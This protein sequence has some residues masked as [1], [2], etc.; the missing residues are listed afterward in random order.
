MPEAKN[1]VV[2]PEVVKDGVCQ[3]CHDSCQTKVH[4]RQGKATRIDMVDRGVVNTCPRWK[5]QLDFAYH[6]DRLRSP[7]KRTGERGAGSFVP[8][9]WDEA[10]DT[11]ASKLQKV[12]AEYGAESVVFWIAYTKEPRLYFHRLAHAFGSPNYCTESSNC[13]TATLLASIVTYGADYGRLNAQS[14]K[15]DPASRCKLIWGSSV[16]NSFPGV[17]EEHLEAKK[18]GLKLIVV[19]PCRTD[20]A[21]MADMHLQLRPGTDGALALGMMNVIINEQLYDREFVAKWTVGFADL[22]KLVQK[23][24]PEKVEEITGVPATRVREAAVL[25][26]TQKPAKIGLSPQSTTHCSNG[27]QNHRA[28]ILL[29]ALTGNL[30]VPGG[31]RL[32]PA[33]LPMNDIT[34][35]ELVDSFP[36]GLGVDRFPLW[37]R[38]LREMEANV[39][40]DRIE[41]GS[42]YP[43]KALFGAGLNPLHF[44]NT[45]HLVENLRKLDFI[46]VT[47][48][49]HTPGTQ[50]ADIVLPLA[51]WVE[52]D[53]LVRPP[54]AKGFVSWIEPAI[55][56]VGESWPEWKIIFELAKR[57]GLGAEFWDGDLEKCFSEILEPSGVTIEDL[58]QHPEGLP[59]T[60]PP[61]PAKHYEEA[62]FQTPSGKVEIASSV[63]AQYGYEPLPVYREP[64]ESPLSR[65]DLAPSFPLVLTTGGRKL[66][67]LHSQFRNIPRLHRMLPEPRVEINPADAGPR[68][69]QSGDMVAVTSPRGSIK[70]RA[71]VTD[72]IMPGVVMVPHQWPGEANVNILV[73]DQTLDPISGFAPF[74]SQLCQVS[75]LA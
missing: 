11:T 34:L 47:E 19:D 30:D 64:A 36:P 70:L 18:R 51:S 74:K 8:I 60:A 29:P 7:L 31:N 37:T 44:P 50:L 58:R 48:Y 24:P 57:L 71:D 5:A 20:I 21:S 63:L 65:P 2:E 46:L 38:M 22:A 49:F 13:F 41:S 17:W 59:F 55:A 10:L 14:T 28:V 26:A 33:A 40:A 61:R 53:I 68:G 35:H 62:G 69:I 56:P 75:S 54:F 1:D 43:I 67:Y 72:T 6:P 16:K 66:P 45:N 9:S 12:K 52:R 25:Y 32:Q 4:I 73:D 39:L 15:I 27:V 23:Y 3:M 42:P